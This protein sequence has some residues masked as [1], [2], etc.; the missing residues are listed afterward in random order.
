MKFLIL[1]S[2]IILIYNVNSQEWV[3]AGFV[4]QPGV[5]PSISVSGINNA[6]I[7]NGS[8]NNPKIFRTTNG[9]LNWLPVSVTGISQEIYCIYALNQNIVFVGEGV[10]SGN[11]KLLKTTNGGLNWEVVL[12]TSQNGGHFTG[13]A[14]TK[15]NGNLFG[16]AIAERIYRS[17]NF[18]VNWIE[19]N[20]GVNGVSNAHNSL[21]IVDND[22]Y[23]FGLNNGAA[24]IRLT[25]NNA[26]NWV[27]QNLNIS[28]NY[29]SAIA[30]HSNK[31][32]GIGAT[33]SSLPLISRTTDGGVS[34]NTIN[35]GSGVSGSCYFYWV[36]ATPVVYLLAAN[37]TIKKSTDNGINWVITPVPS[38]VTNL[39][40]FDFIQSANIVYGYA[41]SSNG[42]VIKLVDTLDILTGI[43]NNNSPLRFELKQNYPNPFNPI[44][45]IKYSIADNN[46]VTLKIFDILGREVKTA[47]NE[48]KTSGNYEINFNASELSSGIYYYTLRAGS[49]TDTKKMIINK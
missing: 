18:G 3:N 43:N 45:T 37:G 35:V 46:F 38:G 5:R 19:L 25:T 49:Y 33:S 16:L 7:A 28:G 41:V 12:T 13:L 26:V 23:A 2:T 17:S 21:T 9:G 44:T 22:F 32:I 30:Y 1:I 20:P 10:Y 15:I 47:V 31:L 42:D 48:Y 6:W 39:Y 27:T 24:R 40:H 14:F 36:P 29:T 4:D 34:W 11:A 8:V